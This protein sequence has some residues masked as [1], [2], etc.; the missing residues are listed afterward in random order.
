MIRL[1]RALQSLGVEVWL[2]AWRFQPNTAWETL[3]FS[4]VDT[5][6]GVL[7]CV[8]AHGRGPWNDAE[9]TRARALS[10]E[11]H[12]V[13][14]PDWTPD[15]SR[16]R[17]SPLQAYDLRADHL[18]EA[19]VREIAILYGSRAPRRRGMLP[20]VV[21]PF[22][23]G[24]PYPG[25][26]HAF[27]PW[28]ADW[29]YGRE[30]V[31]AHILSNFNRN[32][33][34]QRRPGSID[35]SASDQAQNWCWLIGNS[36][37]GKSS[38]ARAG[39]VAWWIPHC[40]DSHSRAASVVCGHDFP[41]AFA[42]AIEILTAG[43]NEPFDR[44]LVGA[45][46]PEPARLVERLYRAYGQFHQCPPLL[47]VLDQFEGLFARQ[48]AEIQPAVVPYLET[49]IGMVRDASLLNV[50]VL[51]T[52]RADWL[53]RTLA[54]P[55]L[56]P[57]VGSNSAEVLLS[58]MS[59]ED[60]RTAIV[61]PARAAGGDVQKAVADALIRSTSAHSDGLPMLQLVLQDLWGRR[62]ED[63][64]IAY[65]DLEVTEDWLEYYI[66][67]R[68]TTSHLTGLRASTADHLAELL[69]DLDDRLE[70]R[71][72]KLW[73]D[74]P[75]PEAV[76]QVI[77]RAVQ[78]R[79]V[80]AGGGKGE[81]S[82]VTLAHDSVLRVWKDLAQGIERRKSFL[83]L[84]REARAQA[85][86]WNRN[87]RE[88]D[89][90]YA[91][92][93]L[94]RMEV[95]RNS[96]ASD[97]I[98]DAWL[99]ASFRRRYRQRGVGVAVF[100]LLL[101]STGI[102]FWGW[103]SAIESQGQALRHKD[104]ADTLLAISGMQL[105]LEDGDT[106]A[107]VLVASQTDLHFVDPRSRAL[108]LETIT[109]PVA[110]SVIAAHTERVTDVAFRPDDSAV[111]STSCDG[112]AKLTDVLSLRESGIYRDHV[113]C[114]E[115]A[116]FSRSGNSFATIGSDATATFWRHGGRR[117]VYTLARTGDTL[118]HLEFSRTDET[119]AA[120]WLSGTVTVLDSNAVAHSIPLS[121][122]VA[123][124]TIPAT[125]APT[126]DEVL[127]RGDS[128][129]IESID[130]HTGEVRRVHEGLD[131]N[132]VAARYGVESDFTYIVAKDGSVFVS[133]LE[134][135]GYPGQPMTP[136]LT[137]TFTRFDATSGAQ[138][139]EVAR[140]AGSEPQSEDEL[141]ALAQNLA[142]VSSV[143]ASRSGDRV[144]MTGSQY[145]TAVW[146]VSSRALRLEGETHVTLP[147]A[148]F[149][150]SGNSISTIDE[151]DVARVYSVDLTEPAFR[152]Q[153]FGHQVSAA[154][155]SST[156][157]MLATGHQD[158]TIRLWSTRPTLYSRLSLPPQSSSVVF[159]ADSEGVAAVSPDGVWRSE[160]QVEGL[161][162]LTLTRGSKWLNEAG[163]LYVTADDDG[164]GYFGALTNPAER[165]A[166]G[167][168]S[169][170]PNVA[171]SPVDQT[172]WAAVGADGEVRLW[173]TRN[174]QDPRVF[175]DT[176]TE[177]NGLEF[178][179]N[180]RTLVA[181]CSDG[182]ILFWDLDA[183]SHRGVISSTADPLESASVSESGSYL[184]GTES[185]GGVSVIFRATG[186]RIRL[187]RGSCGRQAVAPRLYFHS[188]SNRVVSVTS[189]GSVYLATQSNEERGWNRIGECGSSRF[190]AAVF[191]PNGDELLIACGNGARLIS[192]SDSGHSVPFACEGSD[193]VTGVSF[194]ADGDHML[195]H[196]RV[197]ACVYPVSDRAVRQAFQS[198]STACL[199]PAQRKRYLLEDDAAALA[200]W[201]ACEQDHGRE[202]SE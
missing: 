56:Q 47:I 148:R 59:T 109:R 43:L 178:S 113:G 88:T 192:L 22:G 146:T 145:G 11:T 32:P 25:I 65:D 138:R 194:S 126:D 99:R 143:V 24:N 186:N 51:A 135:F 124:S 75:R 155:V 83:I 136:G 154:H 35:Q 63:N 152:E 98:E 79:F 153:G 36:G 108:A 70:P 86:T 181:W 197:A 121:P 159:L 77:E 196:N 122:P 202:P 80:V 128:G 15:A 166:V 93:A 74:E 1:A 165:I 103:R 147:N 26:D 175:G 50:S 64:L 41:R 76:A 191:H 38:I 85:E 28:H 60:L 29:F 8:G 89:Y 53:S 158:G 95:L 168:L 111:L 54:C 27:E 5:A 116:Y 169:R 163:S 137:S 21:G 71:R 105:A 118:R 30:T 120:T 129:F 61:Q 151:S 73:D 110:H 7:E 115:R 18:W 141:R 134:T 37:T 112:I 90:L 119:A 156:G 114:V 82:W 49:L 78:A 193:E 130:A 200:R 19:R 139:Q 172:V 72:R 184:V 187:F 84:R 87:S 81:A 96:F 48:S 13:Y 10:I 132:F 173:R 45:G 104:R 183:S 44:P 33:A 68:L 106:T 16:G 144:L 182:S 92:S 142:P 2:D 69:V 20:E 97:T 57:V 177:V 179:G 125:L 123:S 157:A 3:L 174:N 67:K 199:L 107:A 201:R 167:R 52:V 185:C 198:A 180:G 140:L 14:L 149:S 131:H 46:P 94:A 17:S 39:V 164:A 23:N 101:A 195:I 117:P 58:A 133:E 190:V 12:L 62:R 40:E 160:T 161:T 171:F 34:G 176:C 91:G 189:S 162:R 100:L 188:R 31:T 6:A 127:A 170:E 102:S 66:A 9:L 150:E 42:A 4:A 55:T